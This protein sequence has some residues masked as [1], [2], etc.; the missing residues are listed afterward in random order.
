VVDLVADREQGHLGADGGDHPRRVVT[1]DRRLAVRVAAR[2]DLRVDRVDRHRADLD[3]QVTRP[4][5][6]TGRSTS[7]NGSARV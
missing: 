5:V 4:G 2:V 6:G 3:D 7:E 1:E